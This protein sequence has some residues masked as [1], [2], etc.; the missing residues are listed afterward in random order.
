MARSR[1]EWVQCELKESIGSEVWVIVRHRRGWFRVPADT[2][3]ADVLRGV[4]LGWD[5]ETGKLNPAPGRL[6]VR[7]KDWYE[8]RAALGLS[9]VP[10]VPPQDRTDR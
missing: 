3:I 6:N 4:T 2:Q 7:A 5:R 9:W 8:A 1:R 10:G